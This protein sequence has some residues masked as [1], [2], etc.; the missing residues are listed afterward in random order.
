[1]PN[2]ALDTAT[3]EVTSNDTFW[4]ELMAMNS[5]LKATSAPTIISIS[6]NG[7]SH[8]VALMEVGLFHICDD[9][10]LQGVNKERHE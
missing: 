8:E 5:W 2:C 4:K 1:M 9:C 7:Q 10:T 6:C 3:H